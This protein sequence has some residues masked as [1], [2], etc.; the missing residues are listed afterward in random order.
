MKAKAEPELEE[1]IN[2]SNSA[3]FA[4]VANFRR[5]AKIPRPCEFSQD[6]K[7]FA[8]TLTFCIFV[9]LTSL[10]SCNSV[11]SWIFW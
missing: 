5:A 6:L 11:R 4:R 2:S 7:K 3:K 10:S 1:E 9:I 8:A